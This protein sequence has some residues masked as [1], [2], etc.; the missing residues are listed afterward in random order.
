MRIDK[1]VSHA[2][3]LSRKEA[4]DLI[5]SGRIK[6]GKKQ[7]L[8]NDWDTKNEN[9]Y[10]D[11]EI[12]YYQEFIYLM[13]NKPK[14]YLSATQDAQRKCVL[15]LIEGYEK[16][17]LFMVG[18]LDIDTVGLLIITNDGKMAHILTSPKHEC[19][20]KYYVEVE[21]E[22]L[23]EDISIFKEGMQIYD[24]NGNLYKTKEALLEII[25]KDK[26]YITISEGKYHQVKK[27]CLYLNKTVKYLKRI[28]MG[29]L[30][31]D[32]TLEEG[33][34]RPLTEEEIN[35]LKENI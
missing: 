22:F 14:G 3:S 23:Q 27:M 6:I 24:G 1:Y 30:S 25:D 2:L 19:L 29:G 8:K 18:R 28:S 10:L 16:S 33:K 12:L 26:A 11:D 13:L 20:K 21:G 31:L 35:I 7:V 4:R 5:K 32:E 34:Y 9:V 15:D 17:N